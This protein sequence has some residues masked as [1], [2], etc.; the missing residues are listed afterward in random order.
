MREKLKATKSFTYAG[1]ALKA[2]DS[3]SAPRGDA[4]AL[5]AIGRA[6]PAA[7]YQ[8]AQARVEVTKDAAQEPGTTSAP[9]EKPN[10]LQ[11]ATKRAYNKKAAPK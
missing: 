5:Q 11:A 9:A 6:A 10:P 8:T 4:R 2:G 3:F 7:L 1:R